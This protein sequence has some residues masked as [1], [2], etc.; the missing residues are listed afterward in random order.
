MQMRRLQPSESREA[1]DWI[2]ERHYLK[3]TPPGYVHA[4]E[5]LDG[6][7]RIGAML[8]GRPSSRELDANK[9]LELTRVYFVDEAP[10]NTESKA[11]AM[12]RKHI[13][14]W[15]PL[16]RL[17]IAYSDPQQGHTGLIYE[18]D[19]WAPFGMTKHTSGYGWKSREG[20]RSEQCWPKQR[21]VRTP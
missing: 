20:R 16:T 17:L 9:I 7:T 10:K 18:A 15:L 12:M 21:W 8:I 13:R 19:G 4:L 6:K 3:S 14:I 11:L 5:F 1:A 2:K